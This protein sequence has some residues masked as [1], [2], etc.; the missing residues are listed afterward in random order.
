[1]GPSNRCRRGAGVCKG[2]QIPH[3]QIN[4]VS[5]PYVSYPT[6]KSVQEQLRVKGRIKKKTINENL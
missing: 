3:R 2:G 5:A 6:E 4:Q 1:M